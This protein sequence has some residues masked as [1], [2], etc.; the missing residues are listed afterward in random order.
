MIKYF[1]ELTQEEYQKL[2]EQKYTYDQLAKDYPQPVWCAY[3]NAT[4]GIMGCWSLMGFM[5]TGED[6]CK[7]CDCYKPERVRQEERKRV[8]D[9]IK[10]QIPCLPDLFGQACTEDGNCEKCTHIEKLLDWKAL[11]GEGGQQ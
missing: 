4:E 9:E 1:H 5:V 7:S 8:V 3:P 2:V 11:R 10:S 6:C